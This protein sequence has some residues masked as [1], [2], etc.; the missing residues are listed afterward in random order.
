M[1]ARFVSLRVSETWEMIERRP[2]NGAPPS[3]A[4]LTTPVDLRAP[5]SQPRELEPAPARRPFSAD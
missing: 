5:E 2:V 4:A 1:Q 3:G